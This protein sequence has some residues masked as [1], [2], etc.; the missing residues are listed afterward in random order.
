MDGF[1]HLF[2]N[3]RVDQTV[4]LQQRGVFKNR[5]DDDY[6]EVR[7]GPWRNT[8]HVT[9]IINLK[10]GRAQRVQQLLLDGLLYAHA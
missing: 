4:P 1:A 5:T 9:L 6:P 2:A 7:L 10:P 3:S 8:V